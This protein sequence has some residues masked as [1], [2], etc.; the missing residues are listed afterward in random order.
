MI[1]ILTRK[2]WGLLYEDVRIK[3]SIGI[4]KNWMVE[5]LKE[6]NEEA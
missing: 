2:R 5:N 3:V 6:K 1:D 4:G